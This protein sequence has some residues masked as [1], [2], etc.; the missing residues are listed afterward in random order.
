MKHKNQDKI[1]VITVLKMHWRAFK[2]LDREAPLMFLG[3]F[4]HESMNALTPY[5]NVYFSALIINELAG[6]RNPERLW[7]LVFI[8]LLANAFAAL[9]KACAK[10]FKN[11]K[12]EGGWWQREKI[13]GDKLLS[14]DYCDVDDQK[15]HNLRSQVSQNDNLSQWGLYRIKIFFDQLTLSVFK[16][17]GAVALSV[18]LFTLKVPEDAGVFTVLNHPLFLLAMVLA[19]LCVTWLAPACATKAGSYW[20]KTAEDMKQ[21]NRISYFFGEEVSRDRNRDLDMR[22]YEQQDICE[23]YYDKADIFGKNTAIVKAAVGPMGAWSALSAVFST[24]LTGII[25]LF[26]CLKAWAGA[27]GVGSVTQYIA[28]VTALAQGLAMLLKNL[29]E[30]RNNAEFLKITYEYLDIPN[31]MY[32]GSLTTEKRVDREYEVEFRDVSFKYP[33]TDT[34]A[35]RHVSM[36]FKIGQRLAIVG[37][38]GSGKTTFIKLLCRLYDPTEGEILLNGINIRKYQY[39][40][41]MSIFSVVFQDFKLLALPLGENVACTKHF[42]RERVTECLIKAG[43]GEKLKK[44]QDGIDTYLYKEF[45]NTGIAVSGGEAQIIAIARALYHD[46]PFMILD[47]PTAALDPIAE[48]E[49]YARFNEIA[50]DKTTIYISHRLSSC[51]FCDEILVFDNGQIVQQGNHDALVAVE[52][53]KY[54]QLWHAQAQYYQK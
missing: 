2:L 27:F 34:Y 22:M 51:R 23:R 19:L 15:T 4:L 1:S 46:A 20:V 45:S 30:M 11:W 18:S 52:D 29:G 38:N 39:D 50:S 32:Q 21:R 48:A 44:M 16:I 7:K 33:N 41:Y 6:E 17:I 9:L 37:M 3:S 43:F 8:T 25:Y 35:L 28:S 36:K 53:G 24:V 47:E 26:V 42:D 13:Y 5:V 40:E 12:H 31:N 49:V 54:Y 14:L 10:C